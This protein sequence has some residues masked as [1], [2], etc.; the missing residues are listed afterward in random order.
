MKDFLGNELKV[1]DE[2]VFAH[3]SR[4]VGFGSILNMKEVYVIV[5]YSDI[6]FPN[7][8]FEVERKATQLFKINKDKYV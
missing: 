5:S 2:V 8:T 4:D 7:L 3:R 6:R 1:G